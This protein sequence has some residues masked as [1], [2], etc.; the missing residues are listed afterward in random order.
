M[1][2]KV[3]M[4]FGL[5]ILFVLFRQSP[6][7]EYCKCI[8]L[9]SEL[10]NWNML[11]F[12][13]YST[14]EADVGSNILGTFAVCGDIDVYA[15]HFGSWLDP[16]IYN[17]GGERSVRVCGNIVAQ[18]SEVRSGT[19]DYITFD[20]DDAAMKFFD[21][22]AVVTQEACDAECDDDHSAI[23]DISDKLNYLVEIDGCNIPPNNY[24]MVIIDPTTVPK[25]PAGYTLWCI[26]VLPS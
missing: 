16:A 2:R 23:M 25:H 24:G 8:D 18:G 12:S 9:D 17:A 11:S 1:P 19:A 3:A 13:D 6:A 15:T 10:P 7:D 5:A 4:R 14:T 20:G 22:S 21:G 26:Q